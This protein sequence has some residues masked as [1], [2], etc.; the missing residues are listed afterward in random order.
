[1]PFPTSSSPARRGAPLIERPDVCDGPAIWR[2]ARDSQALDLNSAYSYLLWCRDFA[3]TSAVARHEETG[4]P[5]AFVTGYLRPSSPQTLVIW[6]I[7]VDQ[8]HRGRR[9]AAAL[10]DALTA[11]VGAQ[12]PLTTV[13]TTIT[14]DNT[15]SLALF[16]S[17]AQRHRADV[18]RTVLF[19]GGLFPE[20]GHAPELLHRIGPLDPPTGGPERIGR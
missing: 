15:A 13:E 19:D 20:D 6:Q 1:M 4:E 2:I 18:E 11:R 7:A 5:I 12:H 16:A 10:L 3:D 8:A 17:Y 14:P 9:L